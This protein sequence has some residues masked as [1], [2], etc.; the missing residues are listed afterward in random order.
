MPKEDYPCFLGEPR[1]MSQ[2]LKL[3]SWVLREESR[4][5]YFR[6]REGLVQQGESKMEPG[7]RWEHGLA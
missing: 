1:R 5:E 3:W 4:G 2:D 6:L 7:T